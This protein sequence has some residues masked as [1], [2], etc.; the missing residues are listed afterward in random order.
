MGVLGNKDLV[1]TCYRESPSL[2]YFKSE[3]PYKL[4]H[5]VTPWPL[6]I[7]NFHLNL[8]SNC[9]EEVSNRFDWATPPLTSTMG[10]T[11]AIALTDGPLPFSFHHLFLLSSSS[12]CIHIHFQ[13]SAYVHMHFQNR[14]LVLL[15]TLPSSN[16]SI[17]FLVHANELKA[18]LKK[19]WKNSREAMRC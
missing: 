18:C 11:S 2:S 7:L 1:S 19:P 9:V 15:P 12:Y 8:A 5:E 13:T 4:I 16:L 14:R 17:G 10:E 3:I 6:L